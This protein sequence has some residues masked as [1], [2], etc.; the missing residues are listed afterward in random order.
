MSKTY[1]V[2]PVFS[3]PFPLVIM[4][5]IPKFVRLF[6]LF[7]LVSSDN[8][9]PVTGVYNARSIAD[10]WVCQMKINADT[11]VAEFEFILNNNA[12]RNLMYPKYF[13]VDN[14]D[15]E[16]NEVN[17]T[18]LFLTNPEDPDREIVRDMIEYFAPLGELKIPIE[19]AWTE[20]ASIV[21][22]II[23]LDVD[24]VQNDELD[25]NAILSEFQRNRQ[26]GGQTSIF[27]QT[28]SPVP[29]SSVT[30]EVSSSPAPDEKTVRPI[31]AAAVNANKSALTRNGSFSISFILL[32][33]LFVSF[34]LAQG[35][36]EWLIYL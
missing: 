5:P 32:T 36:L 15:Y 14:I 20:D 30:E 3:C 8:S 24:L 12:G 19:A 10:L 26:K 23:V 4:L 11:R 22:S 18:I 9:A 16:F 35:M 6:Y 31:V 1:F 34:P 29:K 33:V 2:V 13:K 17:S 21:A 27:I 25:M 7:S 28:T